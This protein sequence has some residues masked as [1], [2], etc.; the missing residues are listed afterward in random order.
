M[1]FKSNMNLIVF[2]NGD[3]GYL[4]CK[5]LTKKNY[6]VK[7]IITNRKKF[8]F[9]KEKINHISIY[10]IDDINEKKSVG[11]LSGFKA[12]IFLVAGFSQI[13]QKQILNIPKL[14]TINLHA[15][16]LPY[17][18]GGSPLNWQLINQ[19]KFA[20]ISAI[21]MNEG[22]DT[23]NILAEKKFKIE[24]KDDILSL[25]SKANKL[26]PLIA[27]KAIKKISE[28]NLG[29]IQDKSKACYWCQRQ[30]KDGEIIFQKL[31]AK[32]VHCIIRALKSPYP[33]AW[34]EINSN[35]LRFMES[36]IPEIIIKGTAGKILFLGGK[37]P[38][39]IC[40][41][42]AILITKYKSES[43]ANFILKSNMY[44]S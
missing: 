23:G 33:Y 8:K 39:I 12:D 17:Y 15:G 2:A 14:A 4:L 37:G 44:F 16:K 43:D 24:E 31:S 1:Q 40:K 3:R 21:L 19:E 41:D 27:I 13:F 28:G 26:F 38:Y 22:I 29:K 20:G 42:K 6:I 10:V 11:F 7:A 9:F 32:E 35:K 36:V 5:E 18:R 25:H 30:D 34:S